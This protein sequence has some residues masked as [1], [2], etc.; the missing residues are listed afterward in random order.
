MVDGVFA[1]PVSGV[2][3]ERLGDEVIAIDLERGIYYTMI[4][5]GADIWTSFERPAT[6]SSVSDVLVRRY[7]ASR[8][9]V[10]TAVSS[11][12]SQLEAA[13]L[14]VRAPTADGKDRPAFDEPPGGSWGPPLIEAYDDMAN[15]V[16][17]EP[18]HQVD[19]SGWPHLPDPTP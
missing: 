16:L 4:G 2:I 9:E 19:E 8:D 1:V 3:H 6:V 10:W 13:G 18:S 11:F 5:T 15:L 17:R 12:T 7:G 14:L